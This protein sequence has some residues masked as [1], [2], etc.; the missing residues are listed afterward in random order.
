MKYVYMCTKAPQMLEIQRPL[1]GFCRS[2]GR[3]FLCLGGTC[4]SYVQPRL[5]IRYH[6][7]LQNV[8]ETTV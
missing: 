3:N 6:R 4:K 2:K 8:G 1:A 5:I 7:G